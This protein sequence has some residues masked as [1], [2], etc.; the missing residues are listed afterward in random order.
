MSKR[1]RRLIC[2]LLLGILVVGKAAFALEQRG[3]AHA[4]QHFEHIVPAATA[5][6][7]HDHDHGPAHESSGKEQPP[8]N[9][10]EHRL[11]HAMSGGQAAITAPDLGCAMFTAKPE[12]VPMFSAVEPRHRAIDPPLRPPRA[13]S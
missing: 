8:L 12:G 10:A 2:F 3:L 4:I 13:Q 11:L 5:P 7:R 9:D 6:D 1:W